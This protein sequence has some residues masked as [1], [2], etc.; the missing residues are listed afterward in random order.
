MRADGE[1]ASVTLG[2]ASGRT[3]SPFGVV[4]TSTPPGATACAASATN[5]RGAARL[6]EHLG[7][8][9]HIGRGEASAAVK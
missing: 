4:R 8:H 7:G 6:F 9:Y 1:T 5:A 3:A 2:G